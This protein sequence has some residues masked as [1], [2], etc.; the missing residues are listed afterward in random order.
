M[1][2]SLTTYFVF[3]SELWSHYFFRAFAGH[4]FS[5]WVKIFTWYMIYIFSSMF[6]SAFVN[7]KPL[8]LPPHGMD[9]IHEYDSLWLI[10]YANVTENVIMWISICGTVLVYITETFCYLLRLDVCIFIIWRSYSKV[11][12]CSLNIKQS[13]W[14]NCSIIPPPSLSPTSLPHSALLRSYTRSLL[15]LN[16][17]NCCMKEPLD[18]NLSVVIYIM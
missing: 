2:G 13:K 5:N 3:W 1:L 8:Q 17:W 15:K 16:P 7:Y 4:T 10:V 12:I 9:S 11:C 6:W 14:F 18:R